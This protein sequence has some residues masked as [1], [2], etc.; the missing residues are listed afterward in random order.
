MEW[1]VG[2]VFAM[3]LSTPPAYTLAQSASSLK[4]YAAKLKRKLRHMMIAA[5][6]LCDKVQ[7]TGTIKKFIVSFVVHLH[8]HC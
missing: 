6:E 7:Q 2:R 5:T 4:P 8:I 1:M 3:I